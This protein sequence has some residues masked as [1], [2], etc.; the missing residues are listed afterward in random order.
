MPMSAPA[1]ELAPRPDPFAQLNEQ[2]RS[3]VEHGLDAAAPPGSAG[4]L[5]VIAGAGTG[6]TMTLAARVARLVLDFLSRVDRRRPI[7]PGVL[8]SASALAN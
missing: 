4:P 2:Q 3:A 5:L 1:R 6:K 8:P 7:G